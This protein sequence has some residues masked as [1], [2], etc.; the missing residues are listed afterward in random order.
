MKTGQRRARKGYALM[1]IL[2]LAG[3]LL[4]IAGAIGSQVLTGLTTTK[5]RLSTSTARFAAYAGLQ[6]AMFKLRE[7]PA[8][9]TT[10]NAVLM[11]GSGTVS[12][13]VEIYNNHDSDAAMTIPDGTVVP[14]RTV[15]CAAM[16]VDDNEQGEALHA[17]SGMISD[18]RPEL[19]Y[20]AFSD[21][22]VTLSGSSKSLSFDSATCGFTTD[23]DNR[24]VPD[25]TGTNG[26]LGTNR[27][28]TL[29]GGSVAGDVFRPAAYGNSLTSQNQNQTQGQV[30]IQ[31]QSV[32]DLPAPVSVPRYSSPADYQNAPPMPVSSGNFPIPAPNEVEVYDKL[33]V[34][35]AGLTMGPGQYFFPDGLDI[36]GILKADPDVNANNPIVIFVGGDAKLRDGARVNPGGSSANVQLYFVDN[37]SEEGQKFQMVGNSQ[38]FGTA[39]GHRLETELSGQA[40]LYGGLLGRSMKAQDS[41]RLIFDEALESTPLQIAANWGLNGVTEPRPEVHLARSVVARDYVTA[42]RSG[43]IKYTSSVGVAQQQQAPGPAK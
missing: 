11:P 12:Y 16:G 34:G 5:T 13:T 30:S 38:F 4:T 1:T 40:E 43:T 10:L 19:H 39:A 33:V 23:S 8:Y 41:A 26:D 6:H 14:G 9:E 36:D 2:L 21:Q 29:D 3:L 37:S 42:V 31:A 35:N 7:N 20:A 17:M 32:Q 24:W 22:T 15:Y 28:M 27:Y 18:T 25:T